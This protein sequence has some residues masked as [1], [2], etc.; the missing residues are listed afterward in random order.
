MRGLLLTLLLPLLARPAAAGTLRAPSVQDVLDRQR[1]L[2]LPVGTLV[3]PARLASS[4]E[5]LPWV[6]RVIAGEDALRVHLA[7]GAFASVTVELGEEVA[8]GRRP[9]LALDAEVA[10]A[11]SWR[12]LLGERRPGAAVGLREVD[13]GQEV[14]WELAPGLLV[15]TTRDGQGL[16]RPTGLDA[17]RSGVER[18][19]VELDVAFSAALAAGDLAA[20][21]AGIQQA[22][23]F[24]QRPVLDMG[25]RWRDRRAEL[26]ATPLV[27]LAAQAAREQGVARRR[28]TRSAVEHALPACRD[29]QGR[30]LAVAV[31]PLAHLVETVGTLSG[32]EGLAA[33]EMLARGVAPSVVDLEDLARA[34]LMHRG[35]G[36]AP[37]LDGRW[38]ASDWPARVALLAGLE[39]SIQR[40]TASER[41]A[42]ERRR[43]LAR[44][45]LRAQL[46]REQ[47]RALADGRLATAA[48][49]EAARTAL[50]GRTPASAGSLAGQAS[51]ARWLRGALL[52]V[53]GRPDAD[54]LLG[55]AL[56]N[57][58]LDAAGLTLPP[59]AQLLEGPELVRVPLELGPMVADIVGPKVSRETLLHAWRAPQVV[60]S[61]AHE[62][63]I[64][65]QARLDEAQAWLAGPQMPLVPVPPLLLAP[66]V[67]VDDVDLDAWRAERLSALQARRAALLALSPTTTRVVTTQVGF[68]AEV[69]R[70][71][72][73][74]SRRVRLSL[75]DGPL[76]HTPQVDVAGWRYVRHGASPGI[77]LPA[78]DQLTD[79]SSVEARAREALQAAE[80]DDLGALLSEGIGRRAWQQA[81]TT[82]GSP[83]DQ[84]REAAAIHWL[85]TGR[86]APDLEGIGSLDGLSTGVAGG[87]AGRALLVRVSP[88]GERAV[89]LRS[90]F[91]FEVVA[92][93]DGRR[94]LG[95]YE[96]QGRVQALEGAS[97]DVAFSPD[98][99][100]LRVA[101]V[102]VDLGTGRLLSD[103][104]ATAWTWQ[105]AWV[106]DVIVDSVEL[107]GRPHL[108]VRRR[109]DPSP[110]R[111]APLPAL[112]GRD[113]RLDHGLASPDLDEVAVQLRDPAGRRAVVVLD[114]PD[115]NVLARWTEGDPSLG[116]LPDGIAVA[117]GVGVR[118]ARWLP[119]GVQE[120]AL[121]LRPAAGGPG[122]LLAHP[123]GVVE[124]L[125]DRAVL[126][127]AEAGEPRS[128]AIPAGQAPS[129]LDEGR[130]L[131]TRDAARFYLTPVP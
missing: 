49:A 109:L 124:V 118:P 42:L 102:A 100:R 56:A 95:P 76:E 108:R 32:V 116:A 78:Q 114:L 24:G 50:E 97:D 127:P 94:L 122:A 84:A 17:G 75:S 38:S 101:D 40:A 113:W 58:R 99:T 112:D 1:I 37:F 103:P 107:G 33:W 106:S 74:V 70:W 92:V 55:R 117:D 20:A 28:A 77:D 68:Q 60:A 72:G 6:T 44:A 31:P 18:A 41:P 47:S 129:L 90:P 21:R 63:A 51:L 27:S 10:G 4:L 123:D 128:F 93:A 36:E 14:A 45:E 119:R 53:D 43:D 48:V 19:A 98:G 115:G 104:A 16:L 121:W 12:A 125:E 105:A 15:W 120:E 96:V 111:V 52:A 30:L 131:L 29:E 7:G 54:L 79:R 73:T 46:Q 69:Q 62:A 81:L 88:D 83:A 61:P 130:V 89:V 2:G 26:C 110:P 85:L 22:A 65:A 66:G 64:A 8:G 80:P 57:H 39:G 59:A 25:E 23:V 91:L 86:E 3:K 11:T 71:S 126:Y 67:P 5:R 34:L 87:V 35:A 13:G 82:A 9:V